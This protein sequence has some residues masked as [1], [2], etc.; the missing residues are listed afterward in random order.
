MPETIRNISTAPYE[1]LQE[2]QTIEDEFKIAPSS[3]Y[4]DI[5]NK[6][7]NLD[8]RIGNDLSALSQYE[9]SKTVST[10]LTTS[11]SE[12]Y[13][14]MYAKVIITIVCIVI[15]SRYIMYYIWSLL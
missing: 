14:S 2:Y 9:T 6:L 11:Y 13:T 8:T 15:V 3:K 10:K 5:H 4:A 12:M 7:K 1:Y